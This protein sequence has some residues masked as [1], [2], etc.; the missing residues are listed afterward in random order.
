MGKS[1]SSDKFLDQITQRLIKNNPEMHK[2]MLRQE[3][4][5]NSLQKE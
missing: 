2:K 4:E 3:D 5:R 1:V